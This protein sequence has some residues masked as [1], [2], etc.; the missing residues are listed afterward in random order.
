MRVDLEV[1]KSLVQ[2]VEMSRIEAL[3]QF[4]RVAHS[5]RKRDIQKEYQDRMHDFTQ[6]QE[7]GFLRKKART[8]AQYERKYDD[9][10]E[11]VS[12]YMESSIL[13]FEGK[14]EMRRKRKRW[15]WQKCFS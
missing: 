11:M 4:E 6:H 5:Q 13:Y 15:E 9:L 2:S 12:Q 7:D 14:D 1:L 8:R 10:L 3:D